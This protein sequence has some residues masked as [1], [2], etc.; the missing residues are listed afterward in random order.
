MALQSNNIIGLLENEEAKVFIANH[1]YDNT[2]TLAL[3]YAGKV[4]FDL[5]MALKLLSIYK[6]S[7]QK[8]PLLTSVFGA[9]TDKS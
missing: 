8:L 4:S 1:L 3:Q 9:M 2:S 6:K 7:R 5:K